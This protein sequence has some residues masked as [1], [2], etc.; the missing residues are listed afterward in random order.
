MIDVRLAATNPE[1]STLV[2]VSC[3]SRGELNTVAPKIEEIS[4]DLKVDGDLTV[5][6]LING[7]SGVGQPGPPGENGE[8]GAEGPQGPQGP[9]G[10]PGSID[11]PPDPYEGALLGWEDGALAWVGGSVILP[12]GTF[13]PYVYVSG[14]ERL[15]IPQDASDLVNGQA[16]Y[17]SDSQGNKV[18]SIFESQPIKTVVT[19]NPWNQTVDWLA[20]GTIEGYPIDENAD[21]LFNGNP[22]SLWVSKTNYDATYVFQTPITAASIKMY[23]TIPNGG[24]GTRVAF[25]ADRNDQQ[26][27]RGPYSAQEFEYTG[28]DTLYSVRIRTSSENIGNG[29]GEIIIDEKPLVQP[30]IPAP[31][32]DFQLIF[33][34]AEDFDRFNVGDVVQ[35]KVGEPGAVSITEIDAKLKMIQVDG[36]SWSGTDGSGL[37]GSAT[38]LV[39]NQLGDGS[40]FLGT[41]GSILLRENNKQWAQGGFYA[42]VPEQRIAARKVLASPIRKKKN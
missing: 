18:S 10:P 22:N 33:E 7:S 11:L 42:T 13:G 30:G 25:N 31:F 15:D 3:N 24:N 28:G 8:P 20:T 1:D 37:S 36:G 34:T 4:N 29:I 16:I 9:E 12:P 26:E 40:V 41:N 14:D 38:T 23:A 21:K 19:L 32:N 27:W 39:L 17:M 6:G 35:G 2:P 5:T